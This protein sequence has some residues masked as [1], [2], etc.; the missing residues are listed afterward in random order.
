M[1]TDEPVIRTIETEIALLLR[2]AEATRRASP[3][4]EHRALDRAAY[5]I[6]R[7]LETTGDANVGTVATLLGLD[8]STVT[9]QVAAMERD[10][11]VERQRDPSDG[12]GT[13]I[14]ATRHG[15]S[16]L[17]AVRKARAELYE[18][19]L[20]DWSTEDRQTLARLLHRLNESLNLHVRR[21]ADR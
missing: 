9:R 6:L 3:G 2:R 12:R 13:V 16:R 1:A 14:V 15:L 5:V 8:G 17:H 18:R 20:G 7:Q 4:A 19:V 10:G 11:L 21:P